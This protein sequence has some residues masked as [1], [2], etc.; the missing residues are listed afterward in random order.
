M[1]PVHV[2]RGKNIKNA[3][4]PNMH[5]AVI[6]YLRAHRQQ[7][8]A[9]LQ[10]WLRIP[11]ISAD[12]TC[13][14]HTRQAAE[15]IATHLR[16]V[17]LT[18]VTMLP[19]SAHDVVYGEWLSAPG[20]PTIMVYG[21]Y[22]VQPPDPLEQWASP[23]FEP[24]VRDGF[25]HGRGTCDNKGQ[26]MF[27][28]NAI[29]AWLA[30]T[31]TLPVN[32]KCFIEGDEESGPAGGEAVRAEAS[33][34]QCD[35]VVIADTAW[36]D[37]H[38]PTV[39]YGA[40]GSAFFE[41]LVRGPKHDV[42]SGILG[43]LVPN[44]A[45]ALCQA[46]AQAKDAQGRIQIPG[47]LDDIAPM[48]PREQQMIAAHPIDVDAVKRTTGA[49]N[50]IPPEPGQ[51]HRA[52]NCARPT[53]DIV[54]MVSGYTG[55]GTK[56]IIPE[57]ARAKINCRLVPGQDPKKFAERMTAFFAK[58]LPSYVAW[59]CVTT[60]AA[61]AWLNDF[62]NPYFRT[63]VDIAGQALGM[64]VILAREPASIPIVSTMREVLG[65]PVVLFGMGLP[66]DGI[67]SP[68]EKF[69]LQQYHRGAECYAALFEAYG[70]MQKGK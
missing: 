6:D 46:L 23:P 70:G 38:T 44:P 36:S 32:I 66:D 9:T 69:S 45:V 53:F 27:I 55:H 33:R 56:T 63:T 17:G 65:V 30:T 68:F 14:P 4:E 37:A 39:L 20:K 59:E 40:R 47:F 43:G 62:E 35:A 64:K 60:H 58:H 15:F 21:H 31:G 18:N 51:T 28:I 48:N 13:D 19:T 67:H 1:I 61:P 29:E 22:D 5:T 54:G 10:D 25:L 24:V 7:H 42:H 41:I 3:V 34:L 50:L 16:R 52:M 12:P 26:I 8:V 2:D 57:T 11:S 49:R